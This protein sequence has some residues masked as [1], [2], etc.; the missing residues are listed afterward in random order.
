MKVEICTFTPKT[1][2]SLQWL[3]QGKKSVICH[4]EAFLDSLVVKFPANSDF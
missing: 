2:R 1:K 3:K 4:F